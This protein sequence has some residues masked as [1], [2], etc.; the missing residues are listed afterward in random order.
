MLYLCHLSLYF[1]F[2]HPNLEERAHLHPY[3]N[4]WCPPPMLCDGFQSGQPQGFF[5]QSY[6]RLAR[7]LYFCC[8][9]LALAR[10]P[11]CT[12]RKPVTCD[13]WSTIQHPLMNHRK[14][15][16]D[17]R[18]YDRY[19]VNRMASTVGAMIY[20]EK[21]L[22]LGDLSLD[23]CCHCLCVWFL[24]TITIFLLLMPPR[25]RGGIMSGFDSIRLDPEEWL[26]ISIRHKMIEVILSRDNTNNFHVIKSII[27]FWSIR[28]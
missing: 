28:N 15:R 21:Y 4:V 6:F 20:H 13:H 11:S 17:R 19:N 24:W 10:P 9:W 2:S 5:H 23:I 22:S 14:C 26:H 12:R 25:K 1:P 16:N 27:N 7:Q 3:T 18:V 8:Y